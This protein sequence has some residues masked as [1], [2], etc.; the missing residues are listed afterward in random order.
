[1]VN[2]DNWN[3]NMDKHA[4]VRIQSTPKMTDIIIQSLSPELNRTSSRIA[5]ELKGSPGGDQLILAVKAQDV[6]A[7]RAALNSYLRWIKCAI[8]INQELLDK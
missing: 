3:D 2:E 7:L 8:E 1:M 5:I 4:E 6:N